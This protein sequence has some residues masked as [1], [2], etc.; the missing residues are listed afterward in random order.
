M[1]E[2]S[3]P[4]KKH[5]ELN[6][7]KSCHFVEAIPKFINYIKNFF[8][9]TMKKFG[10]IKEIE[11][12]Q[13]TSKIVYVTYLRDIEQNILNYMLLS[14]TNFSQI[15]NK[16]SEDDFTFIVHKFIFIQILSLE[17]MLL[18]DNFYGV[19]DANELLKMFSEV[20]HESE[21][22]KIASTLNILSQ[23]PSMNIDRDLE[24]I[25]A[26]SMEK[27]IAKNSCIIQRS[28]TIETIHGLTS[29]D[30]INETLM[31][32]RTT[33]IFELPPELHNNFRDTF[34][35][36]EL[37]DG[38]NEITIEFYENNRHPDYIE[39][40]YF[41]KDVNALRWF[42]NV[43]DW[44][45]KYKLSEDVF[46]RDKEALQNLNELDIS[47]KGINEL[48]KEIGALVNMTSLK[49]NDNNIEELPHEIG[50]L[51]NLSI[52]SMNNNNIKELPPELY[53]LT[54]LLVLLCSNNSISFVSQDIINL[55]NL[56]GFFAKNNEI[57]K[58]PE[59]LLKLSKLE[60]L[61]LSENRLKVMPN[62]ITDL[63]SL[64]ML[65][66]SD[67]DI[68][69]L[70]QS[71]ARLT[72][73]ESLYIRDTQITEIPIELLKLKKINDLTI[74]DDLLPFIAKHIEY[75]DVD[76]INLSASGIQESSEIVQGL[77][78]KLD[79]EIW[80]EDKDKKENGCVRLSK[81]KE[82]VSEIM[83]QEEQKDSS[84]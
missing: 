15:K 76:T 45:D 42:D 83:P 53:Q 52:L 82:E 71:I 9:S 28:G 16:L 78:L 68:K 17:E 1:R 8:L 22:A 50:K 38:K 29:F 2:K 81:C 64:N 19:T 26:I 10:I 18:S 36:M 49:I 14:S 51:T 48:P 20:L 46:P 69:E 37:E 59:N 25:N 63:S 34:E 66:L 67:N 43:C 65:A 75:L 6:K 32:V 41:K 84:M 23:P 80:I 7:P 13:N 79:R 12:L 60:V 74:N 56:I 5:S 73:L 31:S 58:F 39:S 3:L 4:N 21:N 57:V 62:D 70:P 47:N 44:A 55:Q 77:N 30:F 35:A 24:I 40:F 72:N 54:N 33:N 61:C 11:A 27:E